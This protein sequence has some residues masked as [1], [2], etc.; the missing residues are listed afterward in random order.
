[1]LLHQMSLPFLRE[2]TLHLCVRHVTIHGRPF[3]SLYDESFRTL[4]RE[5]LH[6]V[7]KRRAPKDQMKITVSLIQE[8]VSEISKV[9]QEKITEELRGKFL[10]FMMDVASRHQ[11]S[12]LGV[13]VQFV[14]KGELK[15]RTL[16]MEKIRKRHTAKNLSEMLS[17]ML[18]IYSIPVSNMISMTTDNGSNMIATSNELN[19]LAAEE[20]DDW[21]DN[22]LSNTIL[23]A[24]DG[25]NRNELLTEIAE[26]LYESHNFKP[27][28]F[29]HVSPI[30]CGGHTLQLAVNSALENSKCIFDLNISV[31]EV[32]DAARKVAKELRNQIWI[33]ELEKK[34]APIPV[35][36]NKTRWFSNYIMVG[37]FT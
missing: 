7:N 11:R 10:S 15:L 19:E 13:S 17:Q 14:E 1:M 35:I 26:E 3:T 29:Q 18:E 22:R 5:R 32:I 16:M 28:D 12:I 21:S 2:S 27:M 30:R 25:E 8:K 31:E 20:S 37:M 6:Y 9:V 23:S 4:L 34:N 33:I 24:V 36:D